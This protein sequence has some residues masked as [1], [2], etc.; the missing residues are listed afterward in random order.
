MLVYF[1]ASVSA[2]EQFIK[3]YTFIIETLQKQGH[4]VIAD[5]ILTGNEEKIRLLS[6]DERLKYHEKVEKWIHTCDFIVA[7]VSFPSTSIGYEV[8]LGLRVGK[9]VL[10]LH[11]IGDAPSLLGQHKDEK[12]VAERYTLQ[13]VSEILKN[14]AGY[15]EG[16]HDLRFTFFINPRL[17]TFL[18]NAAKHYRISKAEY[19]RRL[20]ENDIKNLPF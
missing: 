6:R 11:S 2:K 13:N 4:Q 5:H 19:I 18:D 14:F 20:I 9:P 3:N 16:K 1:T 17:I 15:V 8:A 10:I 7:E 12:L